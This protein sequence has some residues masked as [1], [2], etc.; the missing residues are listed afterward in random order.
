MARAKRGRR[1]RVTNRETVAAD[2]HR[3]IREA[4]PEHRPSP[5]EIT[6]LIQLLGPAE[7]SPELQERLEQI[8]QRLRAVESSQVLRNATNP[9]FKKLQ[10]LGR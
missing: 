6:A 8:E 1:P 5:E 3:L 4:T 9:T 2:L 10:N 7:P